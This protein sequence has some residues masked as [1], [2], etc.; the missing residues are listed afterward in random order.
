MKVYTSIVE[1]EGAPLEGE[2]PLPMFASRN[3]HREVVEDG[4]FTPELK[5]GFGDDTG[6]RYLPYRM[7]DRYTRRRKP[8]ALKTIVLENELLQAVF[9]PDYGG[10]LYALKDRRTG[11]DILYRNPA[12]QPANLAILNAWFSGGIEWNIGQVG[13]TFGTCCLSIRLE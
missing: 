1:L 3:P 13:H 5:A 10:R 6:E 11:R 7:Q 9:L 2:N 4:S 8:M 12:F